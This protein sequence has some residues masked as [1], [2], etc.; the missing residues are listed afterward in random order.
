M[1]ALRFR[2]AHRELFQVGRY[3]PLHASG[4]KRDH[5]IAFARENHKQV[6]II[7]VPRFSY[8]LAGGALRPPLGD[9]WQATELPVPSR[10][11][12]FLENVFTGEKIRVTP[13]RTLLCSELFSHFPVA[14]LACG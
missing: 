12:E 7:A 9:L 1:Q 5:A 8:I 3:T 4:P 2:R 14:L 11:S 6:A 13:N 10:T